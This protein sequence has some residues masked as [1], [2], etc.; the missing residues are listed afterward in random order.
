[1]TPQQ[2]FHDNKPNMETVISTMYVQTSHINHQQQRK[3][4]TKQTRT[5]TTMI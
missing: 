3:K 1:M 4:K 5:T 2:D